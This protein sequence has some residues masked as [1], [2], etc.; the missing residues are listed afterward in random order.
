MLGGDRED[1]G[2]WP[3]SHSHSF[4]LKNTRRKMEPDEECM[5]WTL[6]FLWTVLAGITMYYHGDPDIFLI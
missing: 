4:V 3:F 2:I 1:R 6:L 5:L